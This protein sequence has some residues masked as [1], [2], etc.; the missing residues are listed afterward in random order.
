VTQPDTPRPPRR[1]SR[2]A[3]LLA[4]VAVWLVMEVGSALVLALVTEPV[5]QVEQPELLRYDPEWLVSARSGWQSGFL[6]YDP[7]CIWRCK[8]G[9]SKSASDGG[10][11]P[12]GLVLNEHGHRG[13]P[14]PLKK[15]AG[16]KRVMMLGGSH[17]FGMWV[18]SEEAAI[19]VLG[20]KLQEHTPG[21][22][23]VLN[24]SC[25]GHTSYQGVRYLAEYGVQFEPDIVVFDLGMNDQHQLAV[26]YARPDHEVGSVPTWL[27]RVVGAAQ[28]SAV[29][30]L[31]KHLLAPAVD[32]QRTA[33]VRVPPEKRAENLA[34]VAALGRKHGFEVL[35]MAQVGVSGPGPGNHARCQS[36][37]TESPSLDVC[38]L[39]E[40]M[41][42]DA[43]TYF[44]D[45]IHADPAGH[46]IIGEAIYERIDQL[47][48][49]D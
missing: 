25:P 43:G 10:R 18:Q 1:R 5:A 45:E 41:G 19:A 28:H 12:G 46:R 31:L 17:P 15:P 9:L 26:N 49:L 2:L 42:N 32:A 37:P 33:T 11:Y 23:Q 36:Q 13:P 21:G 30:R 35:Y 7:V 8:P 24:A 27:T 34:E 38:A 6:L 47:G 40:A 3:G 39:F 22:W 44:V 4:I 29:Y 14:M 20:R 48:W 16:L